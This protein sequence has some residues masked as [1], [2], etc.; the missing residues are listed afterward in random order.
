V[1]HKKK[2][3]PFGVLIYCCLAALAPIAAMAADPVV[4]GFSCS[5]VPLDAFVTIYGSDFGD[6]QGQSYVLVGGRPVPVL[7]WSSV[8]IH[9]YAN[10][11][12]FNSAPLALDTAYPVQVILQPANKQSNL[13]N[14]TITSLTILRTAYENVR[15][16][17][18]KPGWEHAVVGGEST[19]GGSVDAV[20]NQK[21]R[22]E[23]M[24]VIHPDEQY[25]STLAGLSGT[26]VM[27]D[28]VRAHRGISGEDVWFTHPFGNDFEFYI[29]PDLN[30]RSLLGAGN[31]G[32]QGQDKEYVGAR[33]RANELGLDAPRGTLGVETDQGL[34]PLAYRP[35]ENFD[36]LPN[37]VPDRVAVFGR[38]IVDAGHDD[39]HSE[40]HPPLL[41]AAARSESGGTTH[42][43]VIGRAYLV[44]QE[45]APDK[46][47]L[48]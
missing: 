40:I 16:D 11:M 15:Y 12:A 36:G 19:W 9:I 23:W 1:Q 20:V 39:F 10:P 47:K 34:V 27:P 6:T 30:Y 3:L 22:Y 25:D 7:S 33:L 41:I 18:S 44:S 45:F 43:T 42:S 35:R 26:V 2:R 28:E 48:R 8:A 17:T 37:F 4:S 46:D 32:T 31:A 29:V 21:P 24:Q 38:W 13:V 14:L 5:Q